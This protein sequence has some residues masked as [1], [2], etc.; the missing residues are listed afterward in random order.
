MHLQ[1]KQIKKYLYYLNF[2]TYS[3]GTDYLI[4]AIQLAYNRPL[5]M[6]NVKDIYNLISKEHSV[7][8]NT[9]KSSIRNSIETMERNT[10]QKEIQEKLKISNSRKLTTKYLIPL[11]VSHFDS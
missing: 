6:K 10:T 5:L 8:P 11:V 3:D 7:P 9:V 2:N 1:K 4:E